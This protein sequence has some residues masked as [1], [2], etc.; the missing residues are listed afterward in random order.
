MLVDGES[1]L[2]KYSTFAL[3]DMERKSAHVLLC[4][5]LPQSD[6]EVELLNFDEEL[7]AKAIAVRAFT[8]TIT[9]FEKLTHD[10]RGIEIE[11]DQPI[12]FWAGQYVDIT[13]TT[14]EGDDYAL[15]LHGKSAERNQESST[16]SSRSTPTESS[17]DSST[18]VASPSAPT[19][20][21]S[22]PTAPASD[23]KTETE[24]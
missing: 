13:V 5:S 22:D 20:S 12:K 10:I 15:V 21:S 11:I 6:I 3:N 19:S 9:R 8:G 23:G 4:R 24:P 7:L 17:P 2:L 18:T 1:N 16:S 14:E